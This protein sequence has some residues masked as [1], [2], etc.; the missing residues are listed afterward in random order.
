MLGLKNT[1]FDRSPMKNKSELLFDP[2]VVYRLTIQCTWLLHSVSTGFF[3]NFLLILSNLD[4]LCSA[5]N[6][7]CLSVRCLMPLLLH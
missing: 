3:R 4:L 6:T 7:N 5:A 2:Y 1:N